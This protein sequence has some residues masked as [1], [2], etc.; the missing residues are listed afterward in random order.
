MNDRGVCG[1]AISGRVCVPFMYFRGVEGKLFEPMA[2]TV[3]IALVAAFI[4]SLTFVPALIAIAVTGRVQEKE[5]FFVRV[6]KALYA[7]ALERT[8]RQPR[9]FI[10]GALVLFIA[11]GLRCTHIG[12]EVI[13]T[14]DENSIA[15]NALRI[16]STAP[17]Q[18]QAMQ[19][20]I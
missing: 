3:I 17:G 14:L 20:R 16:P 12:Q 2:L 9:A 10:G 15:M 7:P 1:Q 5:N 13:P 6:M 11:A 4:L 8:I 19:L 18:S